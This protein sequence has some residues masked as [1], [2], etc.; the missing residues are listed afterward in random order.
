MTMLYHFRCRIVGIRNH[1]RRFTRI[2][3]IVMTAM[4][5]A[6]TGSIG[7]EMNTAMA[8]VMTALFVAR[9]ITDMAAV[10]AALMTAVVISI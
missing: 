7:T 10:V 6:V 3:F 5:A 4:V 9:V 1:V 2:A 8:A